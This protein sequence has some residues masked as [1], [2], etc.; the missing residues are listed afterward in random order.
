M[1]HGERN[2]AGATTIGL[3]PTPDKTV[4]PKTSATEV[5]LLICTNADFL[6]HAAVCLTSLLMNNSGLFFDVVVASRAAEELDQGRLKRSLA[7]FPNH[8]LSFREFAP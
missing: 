4:R 8:N 6:Q 5:H 2:T 1:R 7:R 3:G